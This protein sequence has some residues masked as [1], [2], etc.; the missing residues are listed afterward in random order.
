MYL[1]ITTHDFHL[2]QMKRTRVDEDFNPVYPYDAEQS[3]SVPF[4]TPPFTSS[5][6]LTES[7]SGVLTLNYS[8]PL[9]TINGKLT[10]NVDG[11]LNINNDKKLQVRTNEN[12]GVTLQNNAVSV[13]IGNDLRFDSR[14][15]ITL[16]PV[17]LWTTPSESANCTLYNSSANF[18]LCL[19]R[20][21]A[22]VV[23]TVNLTGINGK[24]SS[25]T[26]N[27]VIVQLAFDENGTLQSSPLAQNVWAYVKLLTLQTLLICLHLCPAA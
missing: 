3:S 1:L 19:T 22:H 9:T 23:G 24:F 21:D 15:Q 13:K 27:S 2:S 17:S 20:N 10:L 26:E 14:G 12:E 11:G 7:P 5:N 18:F 16:N 6:G 25:M 4:V 8:Q